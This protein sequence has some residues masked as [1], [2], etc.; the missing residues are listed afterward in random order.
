MPITAVY[1]YVKSQI[2]NIYYRFIDLMSKEL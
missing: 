2:T 1:Y